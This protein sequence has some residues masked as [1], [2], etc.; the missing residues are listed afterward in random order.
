MKKAFTLTIDAV[1]FREAIMW[2]F[3]QDG[4]DWRSENAIKEMLLTEGREIPRRKATLF[5]NTFMD[6]CRQHNVS[7]VSYEEDLDDSIVYK[8]VIVVNG[9]ES[10][11]LSYKGKER[12]ITVELASALCSALTTEVHNNLF[13]DDVKNGKI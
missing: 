10:H 9:R 6:I 1:A 2:L 11:A 7:F 3:Y 4:D 12:K 13:I 5:Y 8:I